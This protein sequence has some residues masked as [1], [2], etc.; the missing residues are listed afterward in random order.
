MLDIDLLLK[1]SF[2]EY[3]IICLHADIIVMGDFNDQIREL[4]FL[5]SCQVAIVLK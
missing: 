5:G 4:L 2:V 3:L 1:S